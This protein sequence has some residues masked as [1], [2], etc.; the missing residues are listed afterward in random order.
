MQHHE[1]GRLG[2][3]ESIYRRILQTDPDQ[4]VALHLSGV[5]AHQLGKGEESVEP[6]K[7]AIAINPG[8]ADAHHN[9]A[10]VYKEQGRPAEAEASYRD[11]LAINP[12]AADVHNKLGAVLQE[13][14]RLED[15]VTSYRE[16][17]ALNP[18]YAEA[19]NNLGNA[20]RSLGKPEEALKGYDKSLAIEPDSADTHNNLGI[21]LQGQGKHSGAAE[22]YRR[23]IALEPGHAEAH[24][25]LGAVLQDMGKLDDAVTRYRKS[26]DI[27]PVYPKAHSNLIFCMNYDDRYSQQDIFAESLRWEAAHAT[28]GKT[29]EGRYGQ[30]RDPERPLR[31]GYVSPDFRSHSVSHFLDPMIAGHDRSQFE[32]FCYAQ[33][34]NPDIVTRRFQGLA[35]AWCSTV[36]MTEQAIAERIHADEID[37]LVDLAGHTAQSRLLAFAARPAPVQIAWL[38][39]PNTTGLSA[40]D[41]RLTDDV[42]DPVGPGDALHSERLIRL[43]NGFLCFAPAVEAPA[44]AALPAQANGFVTFGSFNNLSKVTPNTVAAW[45]RILKDVPRSRLLM[46]SRSLANEET[47]RRYAALFAERGVDRTRL[48]F[49]AWID[50]RSGQL[51]AYDRQEQFF[52]RAEGA[53]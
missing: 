20:F 45:A 3:A 13:L 6:I 28:S 7:K 36:G 29:Y 42:A 17:L 4:P 50:S 11:V 26:L 25:N 10:M 31:I 48:E 35:D 5:I 44:V 34:A 46:K 23:A 18:D 39:Y 47:R 9:L 33:V 8:Y 12:D 24:C 43:P 41:Y 40:M 51:G 49:H 15:A 21:V 27:R 53:R 22:S 30:D 37:I 32:V 19:L 16:A 2:D 14:G 52:V 1:A 38:G